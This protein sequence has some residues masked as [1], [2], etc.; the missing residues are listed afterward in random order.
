MVPHPDNTI[1]H[2]VKVCSRWGYDLFSTPVVGIERR[3]VFDLP[4]I[5]FVVTKHQA[6]VKTCPVCYNLSR[7]LFPKERNK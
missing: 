4:P 7:G 6:E 1:S 2:E 3:Q 5:K